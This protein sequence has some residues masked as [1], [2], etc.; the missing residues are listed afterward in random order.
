MDVLLDLFNRLTETINS[1]TELVTDSPVTYLLIF[2]LV[3]V[4][5]IA[6]V[7][8]AEATVTAASALAGQGQLTI[9]WVM[10]AAGLGAFVGDNIAYWIGRIAG[11]PLVERILRGDTQQLEA[12]QEQF[13]RRG[14]IFVIIGRFVPG[15]RTVVALGAG[16]LHFRWLQFVIYDA[17]AA[18]VWAIQAALPGF[19]GGS[20]I[21]DE[22]WLA[23]VIG[24]VLSA[25]VAG[26]IVLIQRWRDAQG[27][28]ELPVKPAVLGI[29]GV[30]AAIER[31]VE[32]VPEAEGVTDSPVDVEPAADPRGETGAG[33]KGGEDGA[34]GW[35]YGAEHEPEG[36]AEPSTQA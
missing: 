5:V 12:V 16:V 27:A 35:E 36:G 17:I 11:R 4:D 1:L 10:L 28:R 26:T 19:I 24:F 23:M 20:L 29:G 30:H 9:W 7:I 33:A 18:V 14:G 21:R 25:L 34:E 8:P 6:P 22:P 13:D 32:L 3:A 15:G 31:H 2:A